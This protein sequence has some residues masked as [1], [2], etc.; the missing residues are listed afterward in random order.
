MKNITTLIFLFV[1]LIYS[2]EG[3]GQCSNVIL[4]FDGVDDF[5]QINPYTAPSDFT[6][7]V[8]FKSPI[9]S[10]GGT[11]D[12]IFAINNPRLE[13][14]L[15]EGGV[16]DGKL[17][18]VD[19]AV[20]TTPMV[21]GNDIRDNTWHHA[22]L[23]KSGSQRR[24][25]LD[26]VELGNWTASSGTT[27]GGWARFGFWTGSASD[28]AW[29]KGDID[30][31][32]IYNYALTQMAIDSV[33]NCQ[34]VGTETGLVGLWSFENGDPGGDNTSNDTIPDTSPSSNDAAL[35]NFALMG[36]T[37]N[38][39]CAIEDIYANCNNGGGGSG[40]STAVMSEIEDGDL[41]VKGS[42]HGVI[43][44]SPDGSCFRIK[45]ANDGSLSTESV[46]CP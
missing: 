34:H 14:G 43:I 8:W 24:V 29:F 17:W 44:T 31:I 32:A 13:I 41:Y 21:F 3:L 42:C 38:Y 39:I 45:V 15:E 22:A 9:A 7:M 1:S 33:K 10:N 27:Y 4:N 11:E 16:D 20:N 2:S 12:R 46:T 19:G 26:G 35:N 28:P 5:A 25:Y 37:S 18:I 40:C 36:S 23:T 30:E 6:I